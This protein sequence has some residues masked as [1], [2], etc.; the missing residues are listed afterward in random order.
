MWG[1]S[2]MCGTYHMRVYLFTHR[3]IQTQESERQGN[4]WDQPQSSSELPLNETQ[5]RDQWPQPH[6]LIISH[7]GHEEG[8][9]SPHYHRTPSLCTWEKQTRIFS[10]PGSFLHSQSLWGRWRW[11]PHTGAGTEL[12]QDGH[13]VRGRSW[14]SCPH[15]C[16]PQCQV[17]KAAGNSPNSLLLLF[18]T[19]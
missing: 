7:C 1:T 15:R 6:L 10:G 3:Y 14:S 16:Y 5:G 18:I 11:W 4:K 9:L 19:F 17:P 8:Q 12:L 13:R 2:H